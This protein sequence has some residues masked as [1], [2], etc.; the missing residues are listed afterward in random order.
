M[1]NPE[2][3][4]KDNTAS[5]GDMLAYLIVSSKF[6][7]KQFVEAYLQESLDRHIFW[8]FKDVP[9]LEKIEEEKAGEKIGEVDLDDNKLEAGFKGGIVSFT[10]ASSSRRSARPSRATARTSRTSR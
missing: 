5:L 9:E 4:H 3:R 1:K 7:W 6:E 8:L 2:E 10:S